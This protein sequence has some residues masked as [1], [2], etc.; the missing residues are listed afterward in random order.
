MAEKIALAALDDADRWFDVAIISGKAGTY[1]IGLYSLE[2][3]LEIAMKA[4]LIN[5]D[6]NYPKV[7]DIMPTFLSA[8]SE[9]KGRLPKEFIDKEDLIMKTFRELLKRRGPAGYTFSSDIKISDLQGDFKK[10]SRITRE[11]IDLCVKA[12]K[13]K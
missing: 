13:F 12:V 8:V 6:V 10:Y 7:H 2:M 1:N 4:V 11:L 5:L 3:A 9:N